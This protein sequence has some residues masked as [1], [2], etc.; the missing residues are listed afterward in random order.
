MSQQETPL[1]PKLSSIYNK[2]M[3]LAIAIFLIII[4]LNLSLF[5]QQETK[6]VIGENFDYV[7][8][9]FL[10][11]AAS[12]IEVLLTKGHKKSIQA[13]VDKITEQPMVNEVIVYNTT[14]QV[15]VSSESGKSIN[16]L[17]GININKLNQSDR[18]I[19]FA[20]EIRTDK[21]IA[22]IRI[23]IEKEFLV[24][25][26]TTVSHEQQQLSRLMLLIAGIVGF[27]LTRGFNRFSRQGYRL[28]PS[29]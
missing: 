22:Y 25:S 2:I 16:D 9:Q 21:V 14:G 15:M 6:Q 29:K 17:Y 10:D 18:Y 13:F 1:Y 23:V 3:Q 12:G 11:N 19:P 20:K 7:G 27:L 24:K 8:Q 28:S 4:L 5:S 26:L